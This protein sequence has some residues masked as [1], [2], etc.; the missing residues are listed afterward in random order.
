MRFSD[1]GSN[2]EL[3]NKQRIN[4]SSH[5]YTVLQQDASLFFPSYKTETGGIPSGILNHIFYHFRESAESSIEEALQNR[6]QTLNAVLQS[7][8]SDASKQAAIT[9]ILQEYQLNL[10]QKRNARLAQK[11]CSFSFRID[12]AN[13]QELSTEMAQKEG[14]HY[15]DK[16]GL[17]WKAVIEE[18]CELPY[19]EREKVYQKEYWSSILSAIARKKRLKLVLRSTYQTPAGNSNIWYFKPLSI[20]QDSEKM[21]NY[22]TGM[23][24]SEFDSEWKCGAV[25]LSS[26]IG[27]KEQ[28]SH[29]SITLEEKRFIE[30]LIR[31]N[32]V[33][34]LSSGKQTQ[35][36]QVRLTKQGVELYH[37]IL[38]LRP[39][40]TD[41]YQEHDT[42]VYEFDCLPWQ[43]ETYFFKFGKEAVVLA[44]KMLSDLLQEKYLHAWKA[45]RSLAVNSEKDV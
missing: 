44:P 32:G 12:S 17:Y 18:F 1:I 35:K 31:Q 4:L 33:Q 28:E 19:S 34:Y 29:G 5:A 22:L 21:Y 15:Q 11:G 25:R 20:L 26:I 3:E 7:I 24:R 30:A 23:M 2:I 9:L 43:A 41:R 8:A 36:I 6:K 42:W 40:F 27:C 14:T 38:H 13:L 10:E 45:Y 16:V 37:R 39:M